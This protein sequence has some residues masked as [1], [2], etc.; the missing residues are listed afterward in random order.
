MYLNKPLIEATLLRRHRRFLAD[1][2]VSMRDRR[3]IYCPNGS[4]MRGL[5]TLGSRIWF[6][7]SL[8]ERRKNPYTWELVEV[9]GGYWVCVNLTR[10]YAL[11]SESINHNMIEPLKGYHVFKQEVTLPWLGKVDFLLENAVERCV[12]HIFP[13]TLGDEI[14]RGFFPDTEMKKNLEPLL[15]LKRARELGYRAV[16]FFCVQHNGISRMFPADHIDYEFGRHLRWAI[17]GGVEV[18]A[19]RTKITLEEIT[20]QEPIEVIIPARMPRA[21]V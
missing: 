5:A 11:F 4:P 14:Q 12:V 20:L 8:D 7:E 9:D 10:A 16:L 21:S 13:V 17:E 18:M 19:Y 15:Q 3:T 2:A 1:V 6:C